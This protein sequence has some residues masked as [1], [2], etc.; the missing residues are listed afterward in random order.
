MH[1]S[2]S[3]KT[4]VGSKEDENSGLLWIWQSFNIECYICTCD[5][6]IVPI[7]CLFFYQISV[8]CII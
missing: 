2:P 6:D 1:Y 4:I 7:K 8:G 5:T 3:T